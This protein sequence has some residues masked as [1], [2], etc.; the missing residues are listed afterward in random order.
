MRDRPGSVLFCCTSNA[1]RSPMAEAM[2]K[3]LFGREIYIDSA[4]LRA[5]ALDMFAVAAMDE[6]GIDTSGHRPKSFDDLEETAFDLIVSLSP[7]A[8]HRAVE[9]T[10]ASA[11]ELEFWNTFDPSLVEGNREQRLAAYRDVRDGLMKRIE[12]R[13]ADTA[14]AAGGPTV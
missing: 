13:F 1:L 3:Y 4:G 6:I 8:Q 14:A 10:R 2:A 9:L 5:G 12:Q 11:T 7:Q